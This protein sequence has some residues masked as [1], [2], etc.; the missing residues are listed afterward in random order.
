MMVVLIKHQWVGCG[1]DAARRLG[2]GELGH[3]LGALRHGVLG[4]LA[5]QDEAH[6][7]LDLT[8]GHRRLLG[9]ARELGGLRSD[10][11]ELVLDERVQDGDGLA[12]LMPVSGWTCLRTL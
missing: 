2:G 6:G 4:Q 3:R 9:V 7:G 11:L 1:S 5:G 10:L 12:E 8:A